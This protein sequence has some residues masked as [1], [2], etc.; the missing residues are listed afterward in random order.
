MVQVRFDM[1][2]EAHT[3][4]KV[5]AVENKLKLSEAISKVVLLYKEQLK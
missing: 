2:D 1:L 5:F 4:V 3:F